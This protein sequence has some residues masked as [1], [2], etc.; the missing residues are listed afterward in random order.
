MGF[1]AGTRDELLTIT[2]APSFSPIPATVDIDPDTLNPRSQGNFVTAYIELPD[3]YAVAD[4]DVSTVTLELEDADGGSVSAE[5]TPTEVADHD[6]DGVPDRMVKF[7][8]EAIVALL[9]GRTGD[10]TFRVK[11]EVSGSLFEGTDTV[12]VLPQPHTSFHDPP[13][14]LPEESPDDTDTAAPTPPPQPA[15]LAMQYQVQ[16]GD[17]LWEISKRF[18]TTVDTLMQLN[19][20]QNPHLILCGST[21]NVPYVGEELGGATI[22]VFP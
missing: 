15:A 13:S 1:F 12:R 6:G 3:G 20:L 8:R 4:I 19:G 9:D 7:S 11:G 18:G 21:L 10:I 22:E 5:L 16:P 2:T 17:T 14:A